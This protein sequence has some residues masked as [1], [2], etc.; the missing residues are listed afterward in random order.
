MIL[1]TTIF[2]VVITVLI[3]VTALAQITGNARQKY[4]S[5][6]GDT[7]SIDTLSVVPGSLSF[8]LASGQPFM[9]M[10]SMVI[11]EAA[12]EIIF[13]RKPGTVLPDSLLMVYK[14]FPLLLTQTYRKRDRGVIEKTYAGQYNPFSYGDQDSD[15]NIFKLEGLQ[16]NGNISRGVS[17]GNNQDV[18]VNSSFN[19]QLAGKISDDVEILAAITDNNIPVQ[20]EGNTQ[21]IQDFDKVYIQLSKNKT[22]LIVG[23]FELRRPD[24]Y[25]MNFFKKG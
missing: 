14:V 16:R 15:N 21:Q 23:D 2:S 11:N 24:S 22:K 10:K 5:T 20:P 7:V 6:L 9:E 8:F 25:F 3:S 13:I 4:I 12:S 19:L 17:F 1:K 18:V